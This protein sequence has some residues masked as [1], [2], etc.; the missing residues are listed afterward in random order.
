[1]LLHFTI[2]WE[3]YLLPIGNTTLREDYAYSIDN[4]PLVSVAAG[5]SN[6]YASFSNLVNVSNLTNGY[7]NIAIIALT[8][9]VFSNQ[10]KTLLFNESSSP[11][12]FLVQNPP[13]ITV[14]SPQNQSYAVVN[15]PLSSIPLNFTVD[16]S[17]SWMGYSLDN[18]NNITITGNST[19]TGLTYGLHTLAIYANDTYGNL[20]ASQI[21]A[22][23]IAKPEPSPVM[24]VAAVSVAVAAVVVVAGLLVFRKKRKR[25]LV[26]K[27]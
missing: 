21:I 14:L 9:L 19:L 8:Y 1:M 24:P 26:K 12:P 18:Q 2:N 25:G 13:N 15:A 22:F 10:G 7:H 23:T 4:N 16:K 5:T 17:T 20:G 27:L 11:M 3:Y 6:F